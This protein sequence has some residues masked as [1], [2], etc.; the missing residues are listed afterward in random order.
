M[1]SGKL[2]A[3]DLPAG[4]AGTLL[5]T[6]PALKVG[7]V[8]VRFA[9]RNPA[10]VKIRLAI[11]V[12]ANPAVTDYLSYDQTLPANG[13]IEDTGI[14]CSA[15]EKVWAISDVANVSVRVHGFEEAA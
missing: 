1:A 9:N 5:Y 10:D 14:V 4:G 7:T 2:G 6:V 8:N 3:A 15:G 11:G 12:G 13:I